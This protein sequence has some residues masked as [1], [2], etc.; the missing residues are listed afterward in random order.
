M[1]WEETLSSIKKKT[2][3]LKLQE[4]ANRNNLIGYLYTYVQGSSQKKT[5]K[6]RALNT[7][8]LVLFVVSRKKTRV[9]K[10]ELWQSPSLSRLLYLFSSH[11]DGTHPQQD[12]RSHS[13]SATGPLSLS[14][15]ILHIKNIAQNRIPIRKIVYRSGNK[16]RLSCSLSNDVA[17]R[18]DISPSLSQNKT[19][20]TRKK[21]RIT[22][23][24]ERMTNLS[25]IGA[26]TLPQRLLV[27][28]QKIMNTMKPIPPTKRQKLR[29]CAGFP[30][31]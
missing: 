22:I 15:Q 28:F 20:V 4:A 26:T 27:V 9:A 12:S 17:K 21:K 18:K 10:M 5:H 7:R 24:M 11:G 6:Y 23:F 25:V 3:L 19:H 16:I 8:T 2:E 30:H 29:E 14:S 13:H 1:C 31:C